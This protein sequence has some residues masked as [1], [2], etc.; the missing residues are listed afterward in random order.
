MLVICDGMPRSASTWSFNVVATLLRA[1]FPA[2]QVHGGPGF[3]PVEALK[4]LGPD[5]RHAVLKTHALTPLAC[6]LVRTG[7]AKAIYTH[8]DLADAVASAMRSSGDSFRE[9]L[10][11]FLPG[12]DLYTFHRASRLGLIVPFQETVRNP[13][14]AIGR[15]ARYVL[16]ERVPA[17]LIQQV[18]RETSLDR[19]REK[20]ARIDA[21]KP[22]MI[23][24]RNTVYDPETLLFR[25]H[26]GE[27]ASGYGR[28]VLTARQLA[29]IDALIARH[30][31]PR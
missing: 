9:A 3:Q 23:A 12:I 26:I 29:R 6:A 7:A 5:V 2:A 24:V 15:M 21:G 17:G 19:M 31:L 10:E 22:G 16:G 13:A 4:S 11:I 8:R 14:A 28:R 18:A 1:R 20:V 25:N 27:A 30:G